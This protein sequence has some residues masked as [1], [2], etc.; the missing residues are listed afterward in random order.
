MDNII[1]FP[2]KDGQPKRSIDVTALSFESLPDIRSILEDSLR[3]DDPTL[4][5]RVLCFV[6]G[7][8]LASDRTESQAVAAGWASLEASRERG[9]DILKLIT[10]LPAIR[11]PLAS[12]E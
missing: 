1:P 7:S 9:L 5:I 11:R 8:L 12:G 4:L 6:A 3:W 2:S 10:E